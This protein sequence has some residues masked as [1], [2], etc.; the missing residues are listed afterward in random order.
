MCWRRKSLGL[1][2]ALLIACAI[3][4]RCHDPAEVPTSTTSLLLDDPV[5]LA[6]LEKVGFSFDEIVGPTRL[7]VIAATVADDMAELSQGAPAQ[8]PR[9]PFQPQWLERGH[10]ELIGVVNRL[11]RAAFDSPDSELCGEVRLVYRLALAP[12]ARPVTRLPMTVSVRIPQPQRPDDADCSDVARRWESFPDVAVILRALPPFAKVEMNFQSVHVPVL[13]MDMDDNAEYVLRTF[14]VDGPSLTPDTLFNT[15]RT[16]LTAR[17]RAELAA[18]I[19]DDL[20]AIDRGTAIVPEKFLATRAVSVSPRGLAH[21]ENR[22]FSQIFPDAT[23][24]AGATSSTRA[25]VTTPE[26]LLR[27]LDEGTCPG[28]HQSRG[29]AGFHLLGEERDRRV[30][31]NA[32]GVGHSPHLTADLEWRARVLSRVARGGPSL[33]RPFAAHPRGGYGDPCGVVR[34][35]AA[36][37]CGPGL[38]CRDSHHADVGVCAPAFGREP[39]DPCEDVRMSASSRPEGAVVLPSRTDATCRGPRSDD[40]GTPVCLP[41]WVGFAG[42]MC[43]QVCSRT[44]AVMGGAVCAQIPFAGFESD[45][46]TSLEPIEECLKRHSIDAWIATCDASHPC[47]DDYV[48]ARVPGAEGDASG[49]VPPYLAFQMRVDGPLLDR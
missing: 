22:P 9:H 14:K 31:V 34:G 2:L 19:V 10:F 8:G 7:A 30:A 49:C 29:I 13:R 46:L 5:A 47:R 4:S 17:E 21:V 15:P 40:R 3:V 41:N 37:T 33:S 32:L 18:W 12:R 28:C 20:D 39:G 45:C 38:E 43:S 23:A 27:R 11:D 26:L 24:F 35:F 1:S 44:G 6:R 42:G 36:W 25:F 48:C 16:H